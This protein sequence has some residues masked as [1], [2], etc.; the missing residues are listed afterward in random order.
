MSRL[1]MI[2]RRGLGAGS[3]DSDGSPPPLGSRMDV[4]L[5]IASCMPADADAAAQLSLVLEVES[6]A[7]SDDPRY[8]VARGDWGES[9]LEVLR[10]LCEV[11][12]VSFFDAESREFVRP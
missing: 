8:I 10:A 12:D 3:D 7:D 5:A 11:L 4:M 2:L 9:E 6:A 1:G